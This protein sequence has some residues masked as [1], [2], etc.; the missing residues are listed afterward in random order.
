MPMNHTLTQL[1]QQTTRNQFWV[2]EEFKQAFDTVGMTSVDGVFSFDKGQELVKA[3]I[4]SF[5][6]RTAFDT[7]EPRSTLFLKRY[8][9]APRT[10]QLKNWLQGRKRRSNSMI[11]LEPIIRLAA[12]GIGEEG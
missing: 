4:A 8:D 7:S 6:S 3:N 1:I 9:H 11:E 2:A 12:K 5:R 10:L